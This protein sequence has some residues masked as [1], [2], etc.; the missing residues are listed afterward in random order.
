MD[1][2]TDLGGLILCIS[3]DQDSGSARIELGNLR[4]DCGNTV[5]L[6]LERIDKW[7]ERG[8]QDFDRNSSITYWVLLLPIPV[9]N[10][11]A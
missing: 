8:T 5:F 10:K 7:S 9:G 6:S 4:G 1:Y 3:F 11:H 2:A